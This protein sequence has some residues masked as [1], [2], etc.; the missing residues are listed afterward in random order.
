MSGV[1]QGSANLA[2]EAR[3]Q[4]DAEFQATTALF[5]V[6]TKAGQF[7]ERCQQ[8]LKEADDFVQDSSSSPSRG[9]VEQ[10]IE[11]RQRLA[12]ALEIR[13]QLQELRVE[14]QELKNTMDGNNS[15]LS[16]NL[17]LQRQLGQLASQIS[18]LVV[19]LEPAV[20]AVNQLMPAFETS[21]DTEIE[22]SRKRAGYQ[23]RLLRGRVQ[24]IENAIKENQSD[25]NGN[26]L[27]WVQEKTEDLST[28]LLT[29][30]RNVGGE[31]CRE[32]VESFEME[33]N[34]LLNESITEEKK[35]QEFFEVLNRFHT[36][37]QGA[38]FVS[39]VDLQNDRT[40][41]PK[42]LKYFKRGKAGGDIFMDTEGRVIG[43]GKI[44]LQMHMQGPQGGDSRT[45]GP[46]EHCQDSIKEL[47]AKA[48]E[49]GLELE[50]KKPGGKPT[51]PGA[52][53][54]AGRSRVR[55]NSQS[56]TAE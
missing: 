1:K 55:I 14:V 5:T 22:N 21:L 11:L 34:S 45:L 49:L 46:D 32:S 37:I 28:R 16:I 44:T 19:S 56:R 29:A 40:L 53:A 35:N 15:D 13:N 12:G 26:I 31:L 43:D 41:N 25:E 20:S 33:F 39:Q 50:I 47:I 30:R 54:G 18:G 27:W 6:L 9:F 7:I 4:F 17:K 10:T 52:E 36:A 42:L 2:A 23:A 3:Q 48:L 38:N 51:G 8:M 24:T